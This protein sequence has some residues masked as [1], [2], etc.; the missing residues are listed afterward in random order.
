MIFAT[1][2]GSI[3]MHDS[4]IIVKVS[5]DGG[6]NWEDVTNNI[7]GEERWI[8]RVVTDPVEENTMYIVRTG[9]SPNNK[10]WKT[11]DLGETWTNISGD[12]PDLPCNDLFIDPDN[13]DHMFIANDLGV[14]LST[15]GGENWD[16]ASN[17]MPFVPA[18]DF[19]Y[20]KINDSSRYLRVGTH[21]RSI[22]ETNLADLVTNTEDHFYLN[23][24]GIE[25]NLNIYPNPIFKN[26]T[27]KIQLQKSGFVSLGIYN[28]I[29]QE[30]SI[31][32]SENQKSGTY[33][34]EWNAEG[35]NKGIYLCVLKTNEGMQTKKLI[36]VE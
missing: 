2:G 13:T 12:L 8:T 23:D 19:D 11:T 18:M 6:Y 5:T 34:F 28:L 20:V 21:G 22:Y 16:Y 36:K 26:A 4:I 14:Y 29:G 3:P 31:L 33:K 32:I 35:L 30:I 9:F 25:N 27:I 24:T 17:G 7:P 1:G 15:N 10:V